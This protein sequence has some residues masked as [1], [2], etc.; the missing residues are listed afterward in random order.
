[1]ASCAGIFVDIFGAASEGAASLAHLYAAG[2]GC[3]VYVA[4]VEVGHGLLL[5]TCRTFQFFCFFATHDARCIISM[6]G[7]GV[8]LFSADGTRMAISAPYMCVS[9]FCVV[10]L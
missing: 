6:E 8:L 5:L 2:V 9:I 4:G 7:I 10:Q 1:M 3:I